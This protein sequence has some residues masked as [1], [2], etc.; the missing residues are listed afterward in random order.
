GDDIYEYKSTD[1]S[2][3][4]ETR[5]IEENDKIGCVKQIPCT[6]V[7]PLNLECEST[8]Y[9]ESDLIK[10]LQANEK[11]KDP[12]ASHVQC[13]ADEKSKFEMFHH[14]SDN[15]WKAISNLYC[16]P[17]GRW[18]ATIKK[19]EQLAPIVLLPSARIMCA[20]NNPT[21]IPE[22]PITIC[23]RC[24]R[25]SKEKVERMKQA[26]KCNDCIFDN[27]LVYVKEGDACLAKGDG[28]IAYGVTDTLLTATARLRIRCTAGK[29]RV[30]LNGRR[31]T[32]KCSHNSRA[33]KVRPKSN[34]D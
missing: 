29:R 23:T 22:R 26:G 34:M 9:C 12:K 11:A 7:S 5:V 33:R 17:A 31:A 25:D 1:S 20:D 13:G 3:K 32:G 2:S 8:V 28:D 4:V 15:K 27:G 21:V 18:S 19:E 16:D 6:E 24:D 30:D 10:K 14:E